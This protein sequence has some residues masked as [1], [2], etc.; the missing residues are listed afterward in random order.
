MAEDTTKKKEP[1][2]GNLFRC[3]ECGHSVPNDNRSKIRHLSGHFEDVVAEE[4]GTEDRIGT[5]IASMVVKK[6]KVQTIP[7]TGKFSENWE[8]TFNRRSG[9]RYKLVHCSPGST[10]FNIAEIEGK[11]YIQRIVG[12]LRLRRMDRILAVNRVTTSSKK[13]AR[14]LL[15]DCPTGGTVLIE[16]ARGNTAE[17]ERIR[18][19]MAEIEQEK[20][21]ETPPDITEI[22]QEEVTKRRQERKTTSPKPKRKSS[23]RMKK[24]AETRVQKEV[25]IGESQVVWIQSDV[26]SGK[27]LKKVPRANEKNKK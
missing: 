27:K 5:T 2:Q 26:P 4:K 11:I 16:R 20:G 25:H 22:G 23:L 1:Q 14:K 9:F 19:K 13:M 17:Y 24:N 15:E 21:K 12:N 3:G 7:E 18:R 10:G 6:L 8:R